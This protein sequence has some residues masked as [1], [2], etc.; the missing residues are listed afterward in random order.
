MH[1]EVAR[2]YSILN[3]NQP[4]RVANM[5]HTPS[6]PTPA[7]YLL[8]SASDRDRLLL[9][10]DIFRNAFRVAFDQA[11][12]VSRVHRQ[13]RFRVL[14][15]ACGE[16][17]YAADASER[18]RAALVVGF[19]RDAEAIATAQ[20]AFADNPQL[21]FHCADVHDDDLTQTIGTGFDVA[22]L[23]F[24][25][26]H[27][28]DGATALRRV[29]S[30]LRPGGAILLVD[31]TERNFDHPHPSAAILSKAGVDAWSGFGTYAAGDRH[32]SM[33]TEAGF[34]QIETVP[35]NHPLGGS[36]AAGQSNFVNVV[37]LLVSMRTSLVERAKVISAQQF[38]EHWSKFSDVNNAQAEGM[39]WFQRTIARKPSA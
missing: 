22:F 20:A 18:Y 28:R 32:V 17:L 14:D 39:S 30:A 9:Q 25:L 35:Q 29:F 15:V 31:P 37:Q 23:Q 3:R 21:T 8:A 33:L 19:D 1:V 12:D 34:D 11:L 24:G 2:V 38:D 36:T 10:F 27:F 4:R 13:Q 7:N 16:G 5:T 6:Q 26:S